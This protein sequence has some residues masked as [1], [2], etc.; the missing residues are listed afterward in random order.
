M[1]KKTITINFGGRDY[2]YELV[3]IDSTHFKWRCLTLGGD[4]VVYHIGQHYGESYYDEI[5]NWLHSQN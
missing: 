1:S 2:E 5:N 4:Y 3:K